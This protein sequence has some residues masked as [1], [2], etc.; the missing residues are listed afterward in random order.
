[1]KSFN[2]KSYRFSYFFL[3][4]YVIEILQLYIQ[5]YFTTLV[6]IREGINQ[7]SHEERKRN[8]ET[9]REREKKRERERERA[10]AGKR[11]KAHEVLTQCPIQGLRCMQPGSDHGF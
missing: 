10:Q 9:G 7:Q 6:N 1:M 11:P 8:R 5:P 3:L 4:I 2:P